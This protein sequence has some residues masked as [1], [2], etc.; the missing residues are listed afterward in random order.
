MVG[1]LLRGCLS[2]ELPRLISPLQEDL[3]KVT[4]DHIELYTHNLPP[5]KILIL[6]APIDVS[7]V[8]PEDSKINLGLP[9]LEQN[10]LRSGW[11]RQRGRKNRI[12]R[13]GAGSLP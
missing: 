6:L 12:Q 4:D 8:V 13:I 3:K 9:N 5:E 7:D 2:E 10:S 1:D 11:R